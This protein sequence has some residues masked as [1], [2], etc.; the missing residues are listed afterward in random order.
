MKNSEDN[1]SPPA[2]F[3]NRIVEQ[4]IGELQKTGKGLNTIKSYRSDVVEFTKWFELRTASDFNPGEV[5]NQDILD[6]RRQ[7]IVRQL[8]PATINRQLKTIR[9][10]YRW[11][12][13]TGRLNSNPFEAI[14][15]PL[16]KQQQQT[17]PK[18]LDHNK[19]L[20]LVR[21]VRKESDLRDLAIVRTFLGAGLRISE[22]ASI[23]LSDLQMNDRSGWLSVRGKGNKVREVPLDLKT[24]Q[25][26]EDYKKVRPAG[27]SDR[28]FLGQ[29]GPINQSGISYLIA[30]YA[31]QAGI[32]E[33]TPHTLRHSYAKNLVDCGT[34][35]DQVA[36]LLGHEDLNTT[37]IYTRP[38]REDLELAVRKAA[39]EL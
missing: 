33:C 39:G 2:N 9:K 24:R 17:S 4:F 11:A 8:K 21:M 28:L 29:R 23:R 20:L 35:L 14:H 18:W 12:I 36:A 37:R 38:S 3:I 26:L 31:R 34:P 30:K 15:Q 27:N 1:F 25:A 19:Q 32:E 5:D 6:Y 10:F 7:L 22:L 13:E 16:V